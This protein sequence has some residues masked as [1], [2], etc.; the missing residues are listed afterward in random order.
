[1]VFHQLATLAIWQEIYNFWNINKHSTVEKFLKRLNE[2]DL[3]CYSKE[4]TRDE[5]VAVEYFKQV[6]IEKKSTYA[7]KPFLGNL[8]RVGK[9]QT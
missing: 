9:E 7:P 3:F 8:G 5:F 6:V 2:K 4:L 1:M